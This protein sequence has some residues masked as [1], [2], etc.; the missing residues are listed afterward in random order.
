LKQELGDNFGICYNKSPS[1]ELKPNA[2]VNLLKLDLQAKSFSNAEGKPIQYY[3]ARN[4]AADADKVAEALEAKLH[5][6][7]PIFER[8]RITADSKTPGKS[9]AE[10]D[11]SKL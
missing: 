8:I 7:E 9:A 2:V 11:P 6:T 3:E 1:R 10:F 4:F 5:K